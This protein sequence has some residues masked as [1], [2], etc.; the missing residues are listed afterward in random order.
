MAKADEALEAQENLA[1]EN[2][3]FLKFPIH[4]KIHMGHVR[5]YTG[6]CSGTI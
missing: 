3:T 6:R 4:L 2:I 5:N 1:K